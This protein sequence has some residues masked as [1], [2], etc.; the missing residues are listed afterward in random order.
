[1]Q[2]DEGHVG[3]NTPRA[4]GGNGSI[5]KYRFLKRQALRIFTYTD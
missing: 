3:D 2:K 1:L 4:F 5:A